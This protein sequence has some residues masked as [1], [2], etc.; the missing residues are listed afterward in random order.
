MN[1]PQSFGSSTLATRCVSW[2]F[3]HWWRHELSLL[4]SLVTAT[5]VKVRTPVFLLLLFCAPQAM[6]LFSVDV[7]KDLA[8]SLIDVFA[9]YPNRE[10]PSGRLV[11]LW[12]YWNAA[13]SQQ[14]YCDVLL[15]RMPVQRPPQR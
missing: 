10:L 13:R 6:V 15:L 1:G 3:L 2:F 7:S 4:L 8:R 12:A 9:G 5:Y 14:D 11:P